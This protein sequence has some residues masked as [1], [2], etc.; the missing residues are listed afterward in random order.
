VLEGDAGPV[1]PVG[2]GAVLIPEGEGLAI[3]RLRP[4]GA[5]E[6]SGLVP[7]DELLEI[8]ERPVSQLGLGGAVEALRGAEGTT[9]FLLVRRGV[10][11][12]QVQ[13]PRQR[14]RG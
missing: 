11:E 4:G 7:G 6:A 2:I 14:T 10:S 9:V 8:D 3:G 13:V 12:F 5:A 1:D